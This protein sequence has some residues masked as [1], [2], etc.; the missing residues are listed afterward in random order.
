MQTADTRMEWM[1]RRP[2]LRIAGVSFRIQADTESDGFE[3]LSGEAISYGRKS[4]FFCAQENVPLIRFEPGAVR[5]LERQLR[6]QPIEAADRNLVRV[7]SIKF[8]SQ[9]QRLASPL[10][11]NL[12][13][14][15]LSERLRQATQP[16]ESD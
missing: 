1:V 13:L 16:N 12:Q 7:L 15:F 8:P 4:P 2:D 3:F 6:K 11:F 10:W 14:Q 5:A 9:N